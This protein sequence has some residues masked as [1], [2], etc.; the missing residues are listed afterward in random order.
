MRRGIPR[1]KLADVLGHAYIWLCLGVFVA[2]FFALVGYSI[3]GQGGIYALANFSYVLG[4][5]RE[6]LVWSFVITG[7]TLVISSLIALPAAYA[8]VRHQFR[9]KRTLYSAL[10]LPLYVPAAVVGMAL[11]L[12]YRVHLP[13]DHV[14]VGLGVRHGPCHVPT[15]ADPHHGG[16]E[17]PAAGVRG[18]SGV[19]RRE[20]VADLAQGR[21]SRSS[22]PVTVP[23]SLSRFMIVSMSTS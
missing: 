7:L 4:S 18:S 20:Q 19:P 22:G 13:P 12:S 11:L 14:D 2:P 5:F 23:A 10:T 21:A 6:N 9:G 3:L 16:H 8:L 17:G 1:P 15:D